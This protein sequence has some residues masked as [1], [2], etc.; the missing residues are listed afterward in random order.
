MFV[1]QAAHVLDLLEYFATTRRPAT[2]SEVSEQM[3]WP[4]SSTFNILFTLSEKGFLY[5]P[6]ARQGYYPSPRWLAL[7][8]VIVD[9]QPLPA[10]VYTLVS[11]LTAETGET[12]LVAAPAGVNAIFVHVVESPAAIKYVA[13]VGHRV[14]ITASASGR[15]ILS[16]YSPR[17]LSQLLRR[18]KFERTT[19][20]TLVSVEEVEAEMKR[21]IER[22]YH[23]NPAGN[24]PDLY[25]VSLPLAIESRRLAV[26]VAGPSYRMESRVDEVSQIMK[27][28]MKRH[29][30]EL[31]A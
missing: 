6:K 8:Q 2:L 17:E 16:Q 27:A 28:A 22:G 7:A 25:G 11:E 3:G 30:L 15:A 12:A 21:A 9:A 18:V 23:K 4:R 20:A 10:D 19:D 14:P 1:R 24:V 31:K 26:T 5:E 29:G 13:H